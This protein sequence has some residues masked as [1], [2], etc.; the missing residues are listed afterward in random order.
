[1]KKIHILLLMT[2]F[3]IGFALRFFQ[4]GTIPVGFH[5]DEAIIGDNANFLLHT[6]H[7]TD[8][9]FLPLQ[10]EVFGDY[11]PTGY[12]YLAMLPIKILGL[13]E[14]A[15]RLPGALLSAFSVLACFFLIFALFEDIW[16]SLLAAFLVSVSPWSIVLSRS[17]EETVVAFFFVVLGFAFLLYSLR[18]E[19]IMYL[20]AATI[21]LFISYFM[22]F[23]PRLFVPILFCAFFLPVKYW[24]RKRKE[25][26]TWAF[27]SSFIL[28]GSIAV[29]LV[30]GVHGGTSRFNQVSIFGFPET[31]LVK[32]EQIREDGIM[33][34]PLL[35]TRVFHNKITAYSYTFINNYLE[36]FSSDFLFTKGGLPN[37]FKVPQMGLV[38]LIEL[39]FILFGAYKLIGK[40]KKWSYI[41]F[42]WLLLAPVTASL[43]VDDIPNVRRALL[44][45]PMIELL[46][47]Y[48]FLR[49]LA[50]IP[51]KA[52][53][54]AMIVLSTLFLFNIGYFLHAYFVHSSIHQN[55]Y[56]NEGY[57][58]MVRTV[59]QVYNKYDHIVISKDS[60]EVFSEILFYTNYN[61]QT[62]L[63]EGATKD[64]P[65]TGF[66]KFFFVPQACPAKTKDGHFPQN[67]K[68]L[69][70]ESGQCNNVPNAAKQTYIKRLDGSSVFHLVY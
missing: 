27:L 36:Y 22:Y 37:W 46:A 66:G 52:R 8:N 45:V 9:S 6:A 53:S 51:N 21:T 58:T 33:H 49:F 50:A 4:L 2:I 26:F 15:T 35:V 54:M 39:P 69:Y 7:D 24:W 41:I 60:G 55:W 47:A 28:L 12:A 34:A 56:R 1:M 38:Y 70:V 31:D 32:A 61:P 16:L 17:T 11:N 5:I 29:F 68:I 23:T 13:N 62:Y 20:V 48:G 30:V 43:T 18:K 67:G 10:T 59:Q 42:V 14:F 64:A 3:V 25:L 40:K 19:K 63:N 57:D 44:M 65:Y